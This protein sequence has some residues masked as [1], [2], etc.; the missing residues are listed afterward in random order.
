LFAK[1]KFIVLLMATYGEGDP[2]D[3]ALDFDEWFMSEDREP[4]ELE[5]IDFAVSFVDVG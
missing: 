2:P 4:N 3:S 1:E 5:N